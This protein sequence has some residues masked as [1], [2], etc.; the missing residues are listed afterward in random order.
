MLKL[1]GMGLLA[2]AMPAPA[3]EI[4]GRIDPQE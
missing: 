3:V 4:D 2:W 1:L